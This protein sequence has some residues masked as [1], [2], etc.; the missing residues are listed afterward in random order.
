MPT[1]VHRFIG[2]QYQHPLTHRQADHRQEGWRVANL[3][4]P[5]GARWRTVRGYWHLVRRN[6]Y[7]HRH[8]G[9]QQ[10]R[11]GRFRRIGVHRY[12]KRTLY[13]NVQGRWRKV[14]SYWHLWRRNH[15]YKRP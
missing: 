13:R 9:R 15:Y 5:T 4:G 6:H 12:R 2:Q 1:T 11:W 10:W 14:R 3:N 8:H 7:N